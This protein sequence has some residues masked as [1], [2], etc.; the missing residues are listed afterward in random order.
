MHDWDDLRTFL[1]ITRHGSLSAAARALRLAQSTVGRR[2]ERF[3]RELGARLLDRRAARWQPT[4]AGQLLRA[5][6]ERMEAEAIA[7]ERAVAGRDSGVRGAVRITASEWLV[8]RVLA[9]LLPPLLESNPELTVELV[10]DPRHLNLGRG[11]AD[12]A[13]RPS[14]F[15]GESVVARAVARLG[16]AVYASPAYLARRGPPDF[17]RGCPGHTLVTMSEDVG[18]VARAWLAGACAAA[19][20]AAR[21]NGREALA[22]LALAGAGLACLPRVLGDALPGLHRLATP[23]PLAERQLW[24]GMHRAA[25]SLPRVRALSRFLAEELLRRQAALAPPE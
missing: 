9:P 24:L 10:A 8:Q 23:A 6:A 16:F 1:A 4:A 19:R 17:S 18:D 3:E 11:E 7:A 21:S 12:L 15:P 2:L 13:L 25:R 5:H 14:R 20:V 22:A